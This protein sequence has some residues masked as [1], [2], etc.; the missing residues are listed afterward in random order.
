MLESPSNPLKTRIEAYNPKKLRVRKSDGWFDSQEV[1]S[2]S[3]CIQT[4]ISTLSLCKHQQKT[5]DLQ[6]KFFFQSKLL[7][8]TSL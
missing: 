1:T 8:F 5:R 2:L 7:V 3:K 4:C 6:Q